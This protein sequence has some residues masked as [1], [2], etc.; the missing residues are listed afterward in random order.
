[1]ARSH[2]E[3]PA[4]QP[5]RAALV[6]R[7][8][9][10]YRLEPDREHRT[11]RIRTV[12]T[13]PVAGMALSPTGRRSKCPVRAPYE[14]GRPQSVR[15]GLQSVRYSLRS[16]R[17]R[18][19]PTGGS[20]F[21]VRYGA[22]PNG[23]SARELVWE[24]YP[25]VWSSPRTLRAALSPFRNQER[26]TLA[27]KVSERPPLCKNDSLPARR[28]RFPAILPQTGPGCPGGGGFPAAAVATFCPPAAAPSS[29]LTA[30]LVR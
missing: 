21:C 19:L 12:P 8:R 13:L 3:P 11:R 20:V 29:P 26:D 15:Y 18:P 23:A 14:R 6:R 24:P 16:V 9:S 4:G 5:P 1:V 10:S 17:Y 28:L 25:L 27:A 2:P 7:S 22:L 30:F